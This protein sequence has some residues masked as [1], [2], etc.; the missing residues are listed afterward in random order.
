MTALIPNTHTGHS[1]MPPSKFFEDYYGLHLRMQRMLRNRVAYLPEHAGAIEDSGVSIFRT[2]NP[3]CGSDAVSENEE[4]E[5]NEDDPQ[6]SILLQQQRQQWEK[7]DTE[8]PDV[9]HKGTS[10]V[11]LLEERE[12]E[13]VRR[14]R[15]LYSSKER[16]GESL[17]QGVG[18]KR[19]KRMGILCR[20]DLSKLNDGENPWVLLPSQRLP[21]LAAGS[22]QGRIHFC[23]IPL[24][25]RD[26]NSAWKGEP[27]EFS[28]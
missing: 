11:R 5:E 10:V 7:E 3:F 26:T 17:L 19:W 15:E 23:K 8:I 2:G 13:A 28:R 27:R 20:Y 18:M 9:G 22:S 21:L 1:T 25:L 24:E 12:R 16:V 14:R 6:V 4:D